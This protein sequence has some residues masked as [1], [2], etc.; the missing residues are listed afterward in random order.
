M[1]SG[2]R[3]GDKLPV[4]ELA[5]PVSVPQQCALMGLLDT[6][7]PKEQTT[8]DLALIVFYYILRVG[9]YTQNR[10]KTHTRTIQFWYCDMAFKNGNT[11]ISR[12]VPDDEILA[13]TGGTLRL[14]NQKNGMRGSLVHR[15]AR[16]SDGEYCPVKAMARR[17]IHMRANNADKNQIISSFW[18]HLGIGH[19]TDKDMLV[20]IRRAVIKLGLEKN[21]IIP[22]RVGTHSFRAGG[23]MALKFAGADRDDIKKMGRWSSD[24]FLLYIHDQIAEYSEGWTEK[25]SVPRS[26]FNL[27]GTFS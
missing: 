16:T 9:E 26:Y 22:S 15:S 21:G 3:R 1:F 7:T 6:A 18:D 11:I 27:E 17:F 14:S 19:V 25:M 2:F 5:V 13:A 23:A 8:G 12:D 24:T 20:E 10:R 4:P